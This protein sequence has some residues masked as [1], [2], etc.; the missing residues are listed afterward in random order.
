MSKPQTEYQ[1]IILEP[2][3]AN[4]TADNAEDAIKKLKLKPYQTLRELRKI[5]R[6]S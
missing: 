3:I 1:A 4:V 6:P 2:I 5:C